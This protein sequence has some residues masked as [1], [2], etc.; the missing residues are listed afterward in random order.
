MCCSLVLCAHRDIL[1]ASIAD[2]LVTVHIWKVAQ[3]S[4]LDMHSGTSKVHGMLLVLIFIEESHRQK[5][6]AGFH[7]KPRSKGYATSDPRNARLRLAEVCHI[8]TERLQVGAYQDAMNRL[9]ER[10]STAGHTSASHAQSLRSAVCA[11]TQR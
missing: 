1:Q 5:F 10:S 11:G 3:A 2:Q 4:P 9:H 7:T 8:C 6:P